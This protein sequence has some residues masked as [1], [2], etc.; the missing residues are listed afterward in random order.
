MAVS[1]PALPFSALAA[2]WSWCAEARRTVAWLIVEDPAHAETRRGQRD[3]GRR[4]RSRASV[5]FAHSRSSAAAPSGALSFS[6][7]LP[8]AALTIDESP[9]VANVAGVVRGCEP[10]KAVGGSMDQAELGPGVCLRARAEMQRVGL[11]SACS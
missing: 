7:V 9:I 1:P 10:A 5:G 3:R 6:G 11:A 8:V 4:A 2:A